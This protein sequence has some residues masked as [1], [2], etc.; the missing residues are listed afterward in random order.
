MGHEIERSDKMGSTE[1]REWHGLGIKLPAGLTPTEAFNFLGINWQTGLYEIPELVLPDGRKV[2]SPDHR[3]H[4]RM[5]TAFN[6]GIVG[7]DYRPISNQEMAKFAEVL[8]GED[9]AIT[10]ETGGTLRNG[11]RV[12]VLVKLPKDTEVL[13]G[14]VLKNYVCISNGHDGD[15]GFNV[16]HTPIRVVCAN[17]LRAA[18]GN[19]KGAKFAHTGNIDQKIELARAALGI[20][21]GQSERFA[22]QAR[23]LAKVSLTEAKIEDYFDKVYARL[24][25]DETSEDHTTEIMGMW[26]NNMV[27]A[28]NTVKSTEGT[29]WQ[30]FNA[31]SYW[32][33][34]ERSRFK[35][36][37]EGSEGRI[38]S[39]LFG[40][41]NNAKRVAWSEALQLVVAQ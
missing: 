13:D 34:H 3:M 1:G 35:G 8:A 29:A 41:S 18:E 36:V 40:V 19:M 11:R 31:V 16:G 33:D 12:F 39:N 4:V 17:T 15:S 32:N 38:H 27:S 10:V 7:K 22:E 25:G 24:F 14:D 23:T 2:S 30:A 21:V 28:E 26:N 37:D 20:I 9:K 5:D 6:L